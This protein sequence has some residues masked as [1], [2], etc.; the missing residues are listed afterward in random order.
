M[1]F[2][3]TFFAVYLLDHDSNVIVEDMEPH[4]LDMNDDDI[5]VAWH[6]PIH[7]EAI[8][9]IKLVLLKYTTVRDI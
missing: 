2:A 6:A 1:Q 4:Q 7:Q 9:Q 8:T 5:R 3:E